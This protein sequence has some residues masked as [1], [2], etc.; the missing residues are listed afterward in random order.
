[1]GYRC[2]HKWLRREHCSSDSL[3]QRDRTEEWLRIK[4]ILAGFID[5][6]YQTV[7]L[8]DRIAQRYIDFAFLERGPIAIVFHA[9]DQVFCLCLRHGLKAAA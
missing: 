4:V 6:T 1:M 8:G 9:D 2:I 5:N 7:F 3:R